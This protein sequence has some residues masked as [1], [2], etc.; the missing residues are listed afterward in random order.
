MDVQRQQLRRLAVSLPGELQREGDALRRFGVPTP[1]QRPR[2]A[3]DS[4]D[5]SAV[6]ADL[7]TILHRQGFLIDETLLDAIALDSVAGRDVVPAVDGKDRTA[8]NVTSTT[9]VDLTSLQVTPTLKSGRIYALLFVGGIAANA[10]TSDFIFAGSNVDGDIFLDQSDTGTVGG[11]RTLMFAGF[12]LGVAGAGAAVTMSCRMR[13]GSGT[14]TV[15]AGA[16]LGF[17]VET[18]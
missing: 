9:G 2:I 18:G 4:A 7:L 17:A 11:E 1:R 14:G 15:N 5:P 3:G 10:P 12:K 13:V 16:C 8:T 6:L